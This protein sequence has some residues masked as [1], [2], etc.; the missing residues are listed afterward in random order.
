MNG[1]YP[2]QS[3][4]KSR[5][6]FGGAASLRPAGA[7]LAQGLQ[8][9]QDAIKLLLEDAHPP[10]VIAALADG[11]TTSSH[12]NW[13]SSCAARAARADGMWQ[14]CSCGRV[15]HPRDG[16]GGWRFGCSRRGGLHMRCGTALFV[17][18]E[19]TATAECPLLETGEGFLDLTHPLL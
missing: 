2:H 7:L 6:A 15:R 18:A 1:V 17:R 9:V 12:G 10:V 14:G 11:H 4:T 16:Y 3:G 19:D 13:R 8:L 5:F